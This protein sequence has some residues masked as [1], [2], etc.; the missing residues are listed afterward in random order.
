MRRFFPRSLAG[1]TILLLF[2]GLI[3][4]HFISMVIYSFDRGKALSDMGGNQ[5]ARHMANIAHLVNEAPVGWRE[6][7]VEA[8]NDSTFR[9]SLSSE[10][11][12][13]L[14]KEKSRR[15]AIIRKNVERQLQ[16]DPIHQVAVQL[17]DLSK[18]G[19][20]DNYRIQVRWVRMFVDW[21]LRDSPMSQ[22]LRI[23]IKLND[24]QWIN[25]SSMIPESGSFWV[26]STV[27]SVLLMAV[28]VLLLSVW[29]VRRLAAPLG[30]LARASRRLGK[31][32]DAPP[33][34]EIGP[35]EVRQASRAF[36]DMQ[37]RLRSFIENRTRMLAAISHDLRTPITL[38]RLRAELIEDEEVQGK[39][40]ASLDQMEEMIAS[41]LAF[42][43]EDA[44]SEDSRNVDF[45]ALLGSICDDMSDV[46]LP[47]DLDT[48]DRIFYEC[49]PRAMSR[50]LT[51]LIENAVKYGG[52]AH[53]R[54][55]D[56]GRSLMITVEDNGPGIP[57]AQID[58]VF[59]PFYR[60]EQS[61]NPETG[62]IGLGL[63]VART[64]V[65]AHGGEITLTNRR[66]GGLRVA[67]QLPR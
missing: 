40:I 26:T 13:K 51:N 57:A 17:L 10:S 62:G 14:E 61:R 8:L 15:A 63:S 27:M 39:M 65:Q 16:G 64:V 56:R 18:T 28:A 1:Q 45:A 12:L 31:N 21:V 41:T 20:A 3:I 43:R 59:T 5:I 35:I 2:V 66:E 60:V 19:T 29:V 7:I 47:V 36:N 48:A 44:E 58:E 24:G 34:P 49:R 52:G 67:V 32:V 4:T 11:R 38:L 54:L 25:F 53:V 37:K 23:S 50:A 55:K 42:A 30:A 46:G 6:R 9:V 33:L 22:S